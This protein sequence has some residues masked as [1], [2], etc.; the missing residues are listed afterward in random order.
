MQMLFKVFATW[1]LC[2]I[3]FGFAWWHGSLLGIPKS[4]VN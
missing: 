3:V 1:I 4:P 2:S